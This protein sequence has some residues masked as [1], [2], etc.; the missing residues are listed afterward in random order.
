MLRPIIIIQ[1]YAAH[2]EFGTSR[3]RAQPF[4]RPAAA[5]SDE[6]LVAE[7]EAEIENWLKSIGV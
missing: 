4:L 7:V 5:G 1:C 2:V 6:V 3:M